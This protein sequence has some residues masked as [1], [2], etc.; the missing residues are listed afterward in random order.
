MLNERI[1]FSLY[2]CDVTVINA[3]AYLLSL[4]SFLILSVS[5]DF[6][7]LPWFLLHF[8]KA[9]LFLNCIWDCRQVAWA[10][11]SWRYRKLFSEICFIPSLFPLFWIIAWRTD[12]DFMICFISSVRMKNALYILSTMFRKG[13]WFCLIPLSNLGA[14]H[15][16]FQ[17]YG[18]K[19]GW[20][21]LWQVSFFGYQKTL[22][23][24]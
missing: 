2:C 15:S 23:P 11:L 20:H 19:M 4:Q 14:N 17:I 7:S 22:P 21:V 16:P 24:N 10:L 18:L 3:F 12:K 6:L 9:I 1:C 13:L 5:H 8:I